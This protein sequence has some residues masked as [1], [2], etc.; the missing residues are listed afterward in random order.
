L[1]TGQ[2]NDTITFEVWPLVNDYCD[3]VELEVN[4]TLLPARPAAPSAPTYANP[5]IVAD[6]L[7]D[8]QFN[9]SAGLFIVLRL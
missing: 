4:I 2:L 7:V 1:F 5:T 3:Y 6:S 9:N 8:F